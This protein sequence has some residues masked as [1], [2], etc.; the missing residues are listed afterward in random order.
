[1][2]TLNQRLSDRNFHRL[3]GIGVAESQRVETV[4]LDEISRRMELHRSLQLTSWIEIVVCEETIR[5]IRK[6]KE[7]YGR[8]PAKKPVVK[9]VL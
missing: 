9:I 8:R 7:G 5:S 3:F 6:R 1:M 2:D 4:L